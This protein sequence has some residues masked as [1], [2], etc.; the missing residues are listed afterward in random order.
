M[1]PRNLHVQVTLPSVSAAPRD[2]VVNTFAVRSASDW[3]GGAGDLGEITIPLAQ[4]YTTGYNGIN[5][6]IGGHLG[7]HLSR[8]TNACRIKVYDVTTTM[9]GQ[10]HGSPI[11]EDGF[12]LPAP[13]A[14]GQLPHEVALVAR[15]R[16]ANAGSQ[17]VEAPDSSDPGTAVDRPRQRQTGRVYF[18]P[19]IPATNGADGRPVD[20]IR[21]AIANAFVGIAG[22]L[23]GQQHQLSVWSRSNGAFYQ[24]AFVAVD[25]A[26]D[27]IRARGVRPT[28]LT[29]GTLL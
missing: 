13:Y 11:A 9:G 16:S 25:D 6:A 18:G 8:E 27:T 28:A 19:F 24:A 23:N 10:P 17:P 26:W 3:V 5:S 21:T 22:L 29:S 15:L 4:L 2:A 14:A 7:P 12:T 1:A 20:N